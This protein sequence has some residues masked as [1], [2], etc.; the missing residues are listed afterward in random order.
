MPPTSLWRADLPGKGCSTPVVGEKQLF[1]T[2]PVNG[3]DAALAFD[4]SGKET[5]RTTFGPEQPGKHRSGSGSNPS[6]ATDGQG[7]YVYFKSGTLAA[8]DLKGQVRWQTNLV[9]AF[10]RETLYWDQG[11]SPLLTQSA[12]VMARM[13]HGESWLAAFDKATGQLL[14]KVPRNYETPVE[15]DHSYTTPLLLPRQAQE[16]ILVYGAEHL[17]AHKAVDG[18][19]LWSC[20]DFNPRAGQN[21]PTV[22]S[23]IVVRDIAVVAG[24][25]SDRGQPLL[26][27][28]R[29]GGTGEVTAT[30]RAWKRDDT[31][32]LRPHSRRIQGASL[33]AARQ[34]RS[35]V[36]RTGH[37]PN[38]LA[39]CL[40]QN[41]RQLLCFSRHCGW[42]TLC[43]TRGRG[44]FGGADR[45]QVRALG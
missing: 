30:H 5:W 43:R 27:G 29:L 45:G 42:K 37:R 33:L 3:S 15:G 23:P 39:R 28:I 14:W 18:Q 4:W 34:R 9:Q 16:T 2:A 17:T 7:V 38:V 11:S 35:R 10:G 24:G 25:R 12:V 26:Y 32:H 21:W 44:G 8:L 20:G 13:H 36:H 41:Q 6:P 1:L 31:G 19:V 40:P 22:A